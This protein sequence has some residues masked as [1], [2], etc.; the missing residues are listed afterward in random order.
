MNTYRLIQGNCL[1]VL[2]TLP[3][4]S[5]DLIVTDPPYGINFNTNHRI[6][7]PDNIGE[8]K[9]DSFRIFSIFPTICFELKR[10][11]KSD[12]AFYCFSRWDTLARFKS[13]ISRGF[14]VKNLLIWVKNNWS[15]GDLFGAYA[16]QY[17][18]CFFSVLG[19]HIL[20]SGRD[21][22]VLFYDRK[23]NSKLLHSAEKPE[24][25]ISFLIQ[26]S[27]NEGDVVLDPFL[28]S[29]T[30]MK[31]AQDLR[32]NCIGIEIEPKY[33]KVTRDRCFNRTFLDREVKYIYNIH[34]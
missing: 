33:C 34:R 10:V 31:A 12:S 18:C 19:R 15:M 25:L 27:S 23:S 16:S 32:R 17:E 7:K 21:T 20:N 5:I 2:P 30:T 3:D 6:N 28:G 11:L 9:Y 14:T 24:D 4:N 22:D 13:I 1:K 26:K 29:G 8:F